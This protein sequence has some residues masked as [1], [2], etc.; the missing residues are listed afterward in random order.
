MSERSI[1][2]GNA[3]EDWLKA[4]RGHIASGHKVIVAAKVPPA[5]VTVVSPAGV[6][7]RILRRATRQ[8]FLDEC[9]TEDRQ[10]AI[11]H[12]APYY[13]EIEPAE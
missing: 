7:V 13:Y 2:A 5:G 3:K 8:E 10:K 11:D 6:L 12:H 9:P 4:V 1:S